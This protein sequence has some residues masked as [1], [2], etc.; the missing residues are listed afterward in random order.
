MF[1][2]FK[3]IIG[4]QNEREINRLTPLVEK[5]SDLEPSI[6]ALSDDELKGKTEEFKRHIEEKNKSLGPII[7]EQRE[8]YS[9][10]NSP[11]DKDK[12]RA[13]IRDL[14]NEIFEDILPEAFAVVREVARRT[15]G[16]RHFDVQIMGGIVLHE[17]KIAE[18]ATGEG[19]TLVATLPT[20]LN[21]LAGEGV[22]IVTVNDYLAKRDR[23]WMGPIF[24]FL[25]LTVGVIQ[26]D[27]DTETRRKQYLCDIT[28]GT[29]NEFGFDYLRDNLV[30]SKD[31]MVQRKH[32]FAIVDEVDSILV[33]E[34]RTPLIISGPVD[35]VNTAFTENRPV[36]EHINKMQKYLIEDYIKTLKEAVSQNKDEDIRKLLYIVYKGSPK[37]R[38]FL[39]LT[40]KDYKIKTLLDKT[41]SYYDSKMMEAERTELLEKL[42]FTF[43][44]KTRE[45]TFTS[46]GEDAMREKF[47]IEFMIED[48]ESKIAELAADE[49]I[50]EEKKL[51]KEEALTKEY[52]EQ[53]KRVDSIKQ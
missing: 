36:V 10:V 46:K 3:K 43:D 26:H 50:D 40:L 48:L 15:I 51:T 25:G 9:K 35:T 21:G 34:A 23:N 24:E 20:Y 19:K 2:I 49:S 16:M 39:D 29:N 6:S 12:A 7:A 31:E 42:Y 45:V 27:M 8:N 14:K 5:I 4:S 22:H 33:D 38:E 53:Q 44:E 47:G 1:N 30:I 28:Y 18:M 32:N 52:V 13:K 37:Q 41:S 17:G 11:Q